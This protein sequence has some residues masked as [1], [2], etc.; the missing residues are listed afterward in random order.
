MKTSMYNTVLPIDK[1]ATLVFNALSDTFVAI[2]SGSFQLPNNSFEIRELERDNHLLYEQLVA[3][4]VFISQDVDE[5]DILRQRIRAVDNDDSVF[6]M[7]VNP[8]LDC[9]F[10]CWYCYEQHHKGSLISDEIVTR[11]LDNC[12][13]IISGNKN[14]KKFTL[15][16]FGGEP[17]L[18]FSKVKK[19]IEGVNEIC[20]KYGVGLLIGFTSNG[21]LLTDSMISFLKNF[22]C[23]FQITLDGGRAD[24]NKTRFG[25]GGIPSYDIIL[26][27]VLKLLRAYINVVLRINYTAKNI[28]STKDILKYLECVPNDL[29]QNIVVDFQRVWQDVPESAVDETYLLVKEIRGTV[30]KMGYY[31]H[32]NR[33]INGV[34]DSCYGSKTNHVLVNY[35]GQLFG[36]TA[37]GF[38][39]ENSLGVIGPNSFEWDYAKKNIRD[40]ARFS[41]RVCQQCR[42][43]P[44]CGCGCAQQAYDNINN[45]KCIFGYTDSVKDEFILERFEERYLNKR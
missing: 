31:L 33:I 7:H 37:R 42:I 2:K 24:H 11:I 39:K 32:N 27:N 26:E 21:F 18:G 17:L 14:L 43:A 16:F 4:G 20:L 36:C 30:Q 6:I 38:T 3:A 15:S 35:D 9:N 1:N 45:E 25:K 22:P 41:K 13:R 19:L 28:E 5:I 34:S 23:S 8:T 29:R 12:L 44:I 40:N 10:N